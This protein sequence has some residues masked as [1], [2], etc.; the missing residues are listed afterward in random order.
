MRACRLLLVLAVAPARVNGFPVATSLN[1]MSSEP[2]LLELFKYSSI[3]T[4]AKWPVPN[5][6]KSP[7]PTL[8]VVGAVTQ[9]LNAKQEAKRMEA[10]PGMVGGRTN[11][12][13]N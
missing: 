5:Q 4:D 2:A 13:T 7:C 11:K 9:A 10:Q 1:G 8:K 12:G 3:V 6:P